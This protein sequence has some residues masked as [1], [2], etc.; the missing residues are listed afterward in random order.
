MWW[1]LVKLPHIVRLT[2][3]VRLPHV[4]QLP[5]LLRLLHLVRLP[6]L[7]SLCH[8]VSLPHIVI[9]SHLVMDWPKR[10]GQP[11]QGIG[12]YNAHWAKMRGHVDIQILYIM[13]HE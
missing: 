4:L 5:Q 8:Q 12:L 6:N 7:L 11:L 9:L 3:L 1:Q 10:R 13:L 2:H